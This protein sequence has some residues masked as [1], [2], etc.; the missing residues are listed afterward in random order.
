MAKQL[1]LFEFLAELLR[2]WRQVLA[3]G[4]ELGQYRSAHVDH[5][6]ATLRADFVY[7][8]IFRFLG[9][10]PIQTR[11][12]EPELF[13]WLQALCVRCKD[14]AECPA[15]IATA[16]GMPSFKAYCSNIATIHQRLRAPL[17]H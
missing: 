8:P 9:L 11:S 3:S 5:V 7:L 15:T 4:A 17:H 1:R 14:Q 6:I 12:R 10:D 16:P 2:A 13:H